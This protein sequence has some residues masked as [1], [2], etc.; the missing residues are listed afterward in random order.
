[1]TRVVFPYIYRYIAIL[2]ILSPPVFKWKWTS[3]ISPV[4]NQHRIRVINNWMTR[5]TSHSAL[6][7]DWLLHTYIYY[8][9]PYF[10]SYFCG[11]C[12][13]DNFSVERF[14]INNGSVVFSTNMLWTIVPHISST[15]INLIRYIL[16]SIPNS[17][18]VYI[19]FY[20]S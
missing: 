9:F 5:T 18:C 13:K 12:H 4:A 19:L 3:M 1:M 7:Y 16:T 20:N 6:S 15:T 2:W 8:T 14:Q 10:R 11:H 17:C